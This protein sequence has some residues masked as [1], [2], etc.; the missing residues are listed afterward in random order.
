MAP[1]DAASGSFVPTLPPDEVERIR[2]W[3]ERAYA[4][5]CS[6]EEEVIDYLGLSL[7]VPPSVQPITPTSHLL[8]RAVLDEAKK[9]E[10]VLD[11][12]TGCGVNAILAATKGASVVAVDVN[13]EAVRTAR[14]NAE[15]NGVADRIDVRASD[16]FSEVPESFDMM[17][18]DPP[19]RWFRPRDLAE[20]ATT[21]ENYRAMTQFFAE[22]RSHLEQGGRMLI[23]FGTSGDIGYLKRLMETRGF[24]WSEVARLEG[25]RDGV[26]VAYWTFRVT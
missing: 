9:G 14:A 13:P 7:I 8:G 21:D 16:V 25:E 1:D 4:A 6:R 3:H 15:R 22:A 24:S 12:G 11:M 2:A 5:S 20:A 17:V 23:F 26:E 18:F 10:R 19:F